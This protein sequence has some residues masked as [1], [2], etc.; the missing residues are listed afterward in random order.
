MNQ[1]T[2]SIRHGMRTPRAAA[3]AGIMFSLLIAMTAF[4]VSQVTAI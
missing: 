2:A 1:E 4:N 3:I